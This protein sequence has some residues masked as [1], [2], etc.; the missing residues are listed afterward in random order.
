MKN[1]ILTQSLILNFTIWIC[2]I[3]TL[4]GIKC[5]DTE[6]LKANL[7][8]LQLAIS[9]CKIGRKEM[10]I[11]ISIYSKTRQK[12]L[13]KLLIGMAALISILF[14]KL[15]FMLLDGIT[16]LKNKPIAVE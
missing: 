14:K 2:Q 10:T 9:H 4:L 6:E 13:Q 1:Q 16:T 12:H 8:K 11:H 7:G 3:P 5:G 15:N